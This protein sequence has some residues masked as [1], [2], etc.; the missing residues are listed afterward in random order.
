MCVGHS[1]NSIISVCRAKYFKIFYLTMSYLN[2]FLNLNTCKNLCQICSTMKDTVLYIAEFNV[3]FIPTHTYTLSKKI[4]KAYKTFLFKCLALFQRSCKS[5]LPCQ[6]IG[7]FSFLDNCFHN[8]T[9]IQIQH[10]HSGES[11]SLQE[12][13]ICIWSLFLSHKCTGE[14]R[15][16]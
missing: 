5:F 6:R 11:S 4:C 1:F 3:K 16:S 13:R 15:F 7:S 10:K 12:F 2:V 9:P 8:Q 14:G